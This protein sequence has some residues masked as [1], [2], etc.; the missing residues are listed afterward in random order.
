[1]IVDN[2]DRLLKA[3]KKDLHRDERFTDFVEIGLCL[4]EIEYFLNNLKQWMEPTHAN[5]TL[6]TLFDSTYIVREPYGVVLLLC[7]FN[8]PL[9]L[10]LLPLIPIIAAGSFK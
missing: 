5:K 8:Y 1:M 3:V 6:V 2:K 4:Q 7:P 10:L 9:S